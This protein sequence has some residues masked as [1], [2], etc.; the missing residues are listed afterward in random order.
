M[1]LRIA[2]KS[3]DAA[4]SASWRRF[5]SISAGTVGT[6]TNATFPTSMFFSRLPTVRRVGIEARPLSTVRFWVM[7]SAICSIFPGLPRVPSSFSLRVIDDRKPCWALI[8]PRSPP[9]AKACRVRRNASACS[10]CTVE[11]PFGSRSLES[12]S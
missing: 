3:W 6:A 12:G 8:R 11:V 4:G 9:S 7:T 5:G 2:A 1:S 10:P